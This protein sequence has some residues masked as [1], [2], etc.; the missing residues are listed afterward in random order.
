[1]QLHIYFT[2]TDLRSVSA[3][4]ADIYIVIDLIRATTSI[5]AILES[6]AS[7]VFVADTLE[8][9]QQ[10]VEKH[11][12]RLL[13]GERNALPLPGLL[14]AIR[15]HNLRNWILPGVSLI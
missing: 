15:L 1:M 12:G 5:T 6:G 13:C 8:Q 9:A 7:H 3:S 11:P 10:A 14:M 2:P 4:A